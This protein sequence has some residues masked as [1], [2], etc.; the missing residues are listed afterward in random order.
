M[1]SSPEFDATEVK[2]PNCFLKER[3]KY[4][5]T[6]FYQIEIVFRTNIKEMCQKLVCSVIQ[7]MRVALSC[8]F[9]LLAFCAFAL[10][11]LHCGVHLLTNG[12]V[13]AWLH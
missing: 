4:F 5:F 2:F 12:T 10:G 3:S 6:T 7:T 11:A 9:C 8:C 13:A 1:S